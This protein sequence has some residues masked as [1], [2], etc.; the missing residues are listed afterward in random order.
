MSQPA[1]LPRKKIDPQLAVLY[2][3]V[4]PHIMATITAGARRLARKLREDPE[5]LIQEA[6]LNVAIALSSYDYNRSRGGIFAYAREAVRTAM[7]NVAQRAA[8]R[9]RTRANEAGELEWVPIALWPTDVMDGALLSE[10]M[11]P[12]DEA[13]ESEENERF[14]TRLHRLRMRML[15]NLNGNYHAV[16]CCMYQPDAAFQAYLRNLAVV[17]PSN[18]HIS[19]YLGL[20][21]NVID[22]AIHRIK[23]EFTRLA[24]LD[25]PTFTQLALAE[26]RWPMI[27]NS[28]RA[29]DAELIAD[30]IGRRALDARPLGR[31][32]AE[33]DGARR[34]IESYP[35]GSIV[36]LSL[37]GKHATLVIEGRFNPRSGE[38][39]ADGGHWKSVAEL[40]SWYPDC[41]RR[42]RKVAQVA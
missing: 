4:E 13:A 29:E 32:E 19:D 6:R 21:K 9:G 3:R 10:A 27:Y 14:Q 12:E 41:E 25:L 37:E 38:V 22:W 7:Y 33:N 26:G 11:G 15:N 39:I 42:L 5:D 2:A 30:I 1:K 16:F 28:D 8:T 36:F 34:V 24:E 18:Q 20:S 31:I 17:E 23:G 40:V 35:W